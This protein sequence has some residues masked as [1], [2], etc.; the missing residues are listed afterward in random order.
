MDS[1]EDARVLLG[2]RGA[3]RWK[4]KIFPEHLA[5]ANVNQSAVL[6]LHFDLSAR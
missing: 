2:N 5:A 1:S 3:M 6:S 4:L